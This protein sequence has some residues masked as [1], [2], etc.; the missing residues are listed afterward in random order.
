MPRKKPIQ[1]AAAESRRNI[2]K[3][4]AIFGDGSPPKASEYMRRVT[5]VPTCFPQFDYITGVGG[6]PVGR[7]VI[8]HGPSGD[9]K[10]EFCLGLL[11]SYIN[12]GHA[13]MLADAEQTTPPDFA[14]S[15]MGDAFD[16]PAFRS[17]PVRNYEQVRG[18]VRKFVETVADAREAGKIDEDAT[19]LVV[20]DSLKNLLPATV[21]EEL[22]KAAKEG[23]K[24]RGAKKP[25]VDGF[26]GRAGQLQAAYNTAWL[27]ELSSLLSETKTTLVAIVRE[28]TTEGEGFWAEDRVELVGGREVEYANSLRLRITRKPILNDEKE[29]LGERHSVEIY[30]SKVSK[31]SDIRPQGF[32]HTS[33][34]KACPEGFD[35]ARDVFELGCDLGVIEQSGAWYAYEGQ[36]IGQGGENVVVKLRA[37]PELM[38]AIERGCRE[39]FG[40]KKES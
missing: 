4:A 32:F 17:M 12:A 36:K 21:W 3:M 1:E 25:G 20:M 22:A 37:E 27:V 35:R 30:K 33:N 26:G 14:R 40:L 18:D 29:F 15:R 19:A 5:A 16:S 24:G 6:L 8:V 23:K 9:G 11:A 38:R 31:R 7:V 13:G 10:T 39:R 34:G 2:S 28:R